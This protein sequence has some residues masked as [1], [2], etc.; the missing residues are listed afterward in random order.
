MKPAAARA[1]LVIRE[2]TRLGDD[3][4]WIEAR[5]SKTC[6]LSIKYRLDYG[7]DNAIGRQTY[8]LVVTPESFRRELAAS[9]TF[10]FKQEADWLLAQGL[11]RRASAADLLI[12]DHEGPID[13]ALRYSD[14]CVRHKMLDL[15]GDLSGALHP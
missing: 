11:G 4:S 14:E 7:K 13:N 9:R 8:E 2:T 12:F 5:P 3:Q 15:V 10:V 6:E 1:K